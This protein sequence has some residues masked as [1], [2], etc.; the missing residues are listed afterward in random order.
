MATAVGM[1]MIKT[2]VQERAAEALSY[3]DV[4]AD[5]YRRKGRAGNL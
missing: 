3:A 5:K 2:Y 1:Q 4:C